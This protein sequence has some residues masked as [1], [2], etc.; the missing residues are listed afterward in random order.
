MGVPVASAYPAALDS[1]TTLFG[2]AVDQ[3]ELTLA[4][5]ID[6]DDGSFTVNESISSINIPTFMVFATGEIVYA[7][8]K[9]DVSKLFSSVTRGVGSQP[10][11][12]HSAG[13]VI[14][15]AVSANY[16]NQAKRCVIAVET[17]L[18]IAPSGSFSDVATR[19][20]SHTH[21]GSGSEGAQVA[22]ASLTGHDKTAHDALNIDADTLDSYDSADLLMP[23]LPSSS[24]LT[25]TSGEVAMPATAARIVLCAQSGTADDLDDITGGVEGDVVVLG[26]D[27]GD[28]ITI[29]HA[30][31]K[32][33]LPGDHDIVLDATRDFIVLFYNGSDWIL[34]AQ[35]T[36][37][38]WSMVAPVLDNGGSPLAAG[39]QVMWRMPCTM[40]LTRVTT[41]ADASGS[42]TAE[43]YRC[44]W[45]NRPIDRQTIGTITFNGGGLNDMST[46]GSYTGYGTTNYKVEIDGT[47]TPDTFKWSDDG[48]STWDAT[49]VG[50]TGLFQTLNNGVQIKFNATTGHTLGNYWTFTC[51]GDRIGY[52]TLSSAQFGE[53]ESFSNF[54]SGGRL[55]N[56]GELMQAYVP[57]VATTISKLTFELEGYRY[58]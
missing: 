1:A 5:D 23:H 34:I 48:G 45:A 32:I 15:L 22:T 30:T 6:E 16:F 38:K 40:Y 27:S 14:R 18:G 46:G 17:E 57:T 19:L 47:G 3:I 55:L 12:T 42:V 31:G 29:K 28:T 53:D 44:T 43:L 24:S 52:E 11:Q 37:A 9:T 56:R 26:P 35:S 10:A 33:L 41:M 54:V 49:G 8:G 36:D 25:I 51:T 2:D 21:T 7:E 20:G 39:M 4:A 50:M 13:E 58:D